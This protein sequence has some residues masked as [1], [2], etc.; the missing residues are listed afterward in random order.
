[1]R[2]F[3]NKLIYNFKVK[4]GSLKREFEYFYIKEKLL[5]LLFKS[6]TTNVLKGVWW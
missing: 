3:Q 5:K 4:T 1:M 2:I 6:Y